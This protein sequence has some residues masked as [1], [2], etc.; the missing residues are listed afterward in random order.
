MSMFSTPYEKELHNN[1]FVIAPSRKGLFKIIFLT[2]VPPQVYVSLSGTNYLS[3]FATIQL[4]SIEESGLV[5]HTDLPGCCRPLDTGSESLGEWY[6][7][8]GSTISTTGDVLY[9]TRGQKTITLSSA[10]GRYQSGIYCCN[11]PTSVGDEDLCVI[12][13]E[14]YN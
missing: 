5:C 10:I 7:P 14:L 9:V 12:V 13:G 3:S 4:S 2:A 1:I 11:I 6:H 8:D